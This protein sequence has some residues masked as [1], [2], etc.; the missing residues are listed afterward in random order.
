MVDN[1]LSRGAANDPLLKAVGEKRFP[2]HHG[3]VSFYD[4]RTYKS[5]RSSRL[6]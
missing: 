5:H 2:I 1:C 4:I 6:T 3:A